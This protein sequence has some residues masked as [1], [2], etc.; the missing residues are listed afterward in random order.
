M[1][2]KKKGLIMFSK[3]IRSESGEVGSALPW[4]LFLAICVIMSAVLFLSGNAVAAIVVIVL[5]F[6]SWIATGIF[7][8]IQYRRQP[9]LAEVR[10]ERDAKIDALLPTLP[11][12]LYSGREQEIFDAVKDTF[13]QLCELDRAKIKGAMSLADLGA[14]SLDIVQAL[15]ALEDNLG[16][17]VP[18]TELAGIDTV[19]QLT[20]LLSRLCLTDK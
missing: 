5:A 19:G 20:D 16:V 9:S 3:V 18:E 10:A 2:N 1:D 8:E 15:F 7:D 17:N 12:D 6:A 11:D 14:D 4:M 13:A